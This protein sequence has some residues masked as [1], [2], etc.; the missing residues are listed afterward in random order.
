MSNEYYCK[1]GKHNRCYGA[2]EYTCRRCG[3]AVCWDHVRRLPRT[4]TNPCVGYECNDCEAR[5]KAALE[6]DDDNG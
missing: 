4:H 5:L 2:P 6:K 3:E 1:A